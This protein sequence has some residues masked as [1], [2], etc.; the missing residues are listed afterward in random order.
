MKLIKQLVKKITKKLVFELYKSR[1]GRFYMQQVVEEIMQQQSKV[2]HNLIDMVFCTPN[3]LN[4]YRVETFS[5][6]EPET[7]EWIESI[8]VGSVLWD[9]G[10]NVGLYSIYAA[11]VKECRVFSFEPSVFNMELLARNI[12]LNKL[13]H[14]ITIVPV[15]LS[16]KLS[17]NLFRM[18]STQWGGAL[19]TFGENI[20]QNGNP[21]NEVFEYKTLGMTMDQAV[22]LINIP[23]PKYIKMDVD[24]IEH[25]ILNGGIEVL[26]NVE[27]VLVEINDEFPEQS[28]LASNVLTDVGFVL[29]KKCFDGNAGDSKQFNQWWKKKLGDD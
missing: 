15:A 13:Q 9:I 7:L 29:Y 1:A 6:K 16:D 28:E 19:S 8:P 26:S 11:K 20:D 24:G 21:F 27:S 4:N 5:S 18:S 10:A 22:C 12:F 3:W 17:E 23:I 14:L 25:L 2:K